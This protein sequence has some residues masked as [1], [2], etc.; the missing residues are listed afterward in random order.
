VTIPISINGDTQLPQRDSVSKQRLIVGIDPGI[1]CSIAILD[2]DG[3]PV[4]VRTEKGFR[5]SSIIKEITK[6]GQP[7]IVASDV[8]RTPDLVRKIASA[9]NAVVY[10]PERDL[11]V[12]QKE[13]I[14]KA[15][16]KVNR[17]DVANAHSR[18]SLSAAVKAYYHYR[19]K[20]QR[21]ET[22]ASRMGIKRDLESAKALVVRGTAVKKALG[23]ISK[24]DEIR[25][26]REMPPPRRPR[27][28]S[29]L[30]ERLREKEE[31]IRLL[32]T[33]NLGLVG[34][35]RKLKAQLDE[36]GCQLE[37]NRSEEDREIKRDRLY[38]AQ[39]IQILNLREELN[40]MRLQ[41]E[42][43]KT[44]KDILYKLQR[45]NVSPDL[46]P[47]KPVQRFT[48]RGLEESIREL[49]I[50]SGEPIILLDASGGGPSTAET[51]AKLRPS[52]VITFNEMSHQARETL[53][54][55]GVAIAS[56]HQ[57]DI[58]WLDGVPYISRGEFT[59]AI[60]LAKLDRRIR[61]LDD[62]EALVRQYREFRD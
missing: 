53:I 1:T 42:S 51:L 22:Q 9:L 12:D 49:C 33:E 28:N 50:R 10:T 41:L 61:G 19:T 24:S 32:E 36:L 62:V 8:M 11:V 3:R 39:R 20:F 54:E 2:L 14:V 58:K 18:D 52:V 55:R 13:E 37:K 57:V 31:R 34:E 46:V 23:Q 44:K 47:L 59:K 5:R 60:R 21:V 6:W 30:E 26:R 27:T 35:M 25:E 48:E 40:K 16:C 43:D 15:F 38:E 4:H 17:M 29:F 7:I 45:S 56:A